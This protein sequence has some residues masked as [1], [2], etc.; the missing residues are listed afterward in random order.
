MSN[1]NFKK[2]KLDLEYHGESQKLNAFLILITAGLLTFISAFL[3][4]RDN[5]IFYY[6]LAI[7]LI[8]FVAGLIFYKKSSKRMGEILSEI[9]E[10]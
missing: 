10:L 4:L 6:G 3:F 1:K 9:E 7:S 2:N 5:K 8:V